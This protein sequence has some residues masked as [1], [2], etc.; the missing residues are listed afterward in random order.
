[1]SCEGCFSG[2]KHGGVRNSCRVVQS[3]ASRSAPLTR[4]NSCEKCQ[5]GSCARRSKSSST[6][7]PYACQLGHASSPLFHYT[8]GSAR[9]LWTLTSGRSLLRNCGE[10]K[11]TYRQILS[12]SSMNFSLPGVSAD[13]GLAARAD[14]TDLPPQARR[15]SARR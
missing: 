4:M 1:M 2:M 8:R 6:C 9:L 13:A 3:R 5:R 14:P 10:A 7:Q 15:T 12:R 11:T